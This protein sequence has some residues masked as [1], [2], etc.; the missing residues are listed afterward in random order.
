[1][2]KDLI[3]I[4]IFLVWGFVRDKYCFISRNILNYI[5]VFLDINMSIGNI[6][7]VLLFSN[8]DSER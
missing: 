6:L 4:Y 2:K 7:I 8:M 3:Y 1:M 5:M